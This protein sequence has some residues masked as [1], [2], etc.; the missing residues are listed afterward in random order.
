MPV[1]EVA[2]GGFA[3]DLQFNEFHRITQGELNGPIRDR[4]LPKSKAEMLCSRRQQ[5][6]LLKENVIISVYCKRHEDLVQFVN[7][8]A[9]EL[10]FF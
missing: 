8:L 6:N 3:V 5:W 2:G 4:D 7:P 10:F 9:P 1:S